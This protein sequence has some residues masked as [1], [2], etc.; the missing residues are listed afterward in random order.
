MTTRAGDLKDSGCNDDRGAAVQVVETPLNPLACRLRIVRVLHPVE[1]VLTT[2]KS[3]KIDFQLLS[4][5]SI[6]GAAGSNLVWRVGRTGVR[7]ILF[8]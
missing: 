7:R 2:P 5:P 6:V 3:L 4:Q 8:V 1:F